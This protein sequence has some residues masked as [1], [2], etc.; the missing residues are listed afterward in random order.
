[1]ITGLGVVSPIGNTVETFWGNLTAGVSGIDRVTALDARDFE[2]QIAGEVRDFDPTAYMGSKE[3]RR[4]ERFAQFAVAVTRMALNDAALTIDEQNAYDVGIVMNTGSGGAQRVALEEHVLTQR[5]PRRVTPL[6]VPLMAPNMAATQPSMQLGIRGPVICSVAACAA[7]TMA[8]VE[9]LRL[10][11]AGD[12]DVVIAGGTESAIMPL[13]FAGLINLGTLSRRNDDPTRASRPFDRDR[14]GF[15][16]SEGAAALVVEREDHARARGARILCELAGGAITSDAFHITAP[17]PDGAG[18]AHAMTRALRDAHMQ[19]SDVD[20]IAAHGTGTEL[21]DVAET[22]AIKRAFGEHA[23][24]LAISANKSMVGHLF[25]AA[26]AISAL[27]C[28]LAIRDG[29]IPPTINLDYPDPACDLDYVPHVARR[30][31]VRAAMANAFGF[32]GQNAIA[33][34]RS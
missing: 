9:A 32:G 12:A 26:G 28:V 34:F 17:L 21:N 27:A 6:F 7:G 18:A 20:Y 4:M 24:R 33:I 30:Q 10:I 23:Y 15:V 3:A 22:V 31:P 11:R 1:V 29:L 13:G 2:V 14:D 8:V 19:P 5:G 16:L 25:G